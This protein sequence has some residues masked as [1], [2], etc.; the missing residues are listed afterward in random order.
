MIRRTTLLVVAILL[1]AAGCR[2]CASPY[3]YCGPLFTGRDCTPCAPD[4]RAGSI[5]CDQ[6]TAV[7]PCNSEV[8]DPS[9]E[10][11]RPIPDQLAGESVEGPVLIVGE[12]APATYF[13][14]VPSGPQIFHPASQP[15]HPAT[16]YSQPAPW[17]PQR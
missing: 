9:D 16:G 15:I 13:D 17:L 14:E 3:D 12:A 2:Y 4:A 8:V 7:L 1:A 6:A 11:L 5:F 10:A